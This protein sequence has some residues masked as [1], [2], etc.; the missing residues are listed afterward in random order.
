[1]DFLTESLRSR[2][3]LRVR[4]SSKRTNSKCDDW[5][6]VSSNQELTNIQQKLTGEDEAVHWNSK[7]SFL[8][9]AGLFCRLPSLSQSQGP[10][11]LQTKWAEP[12]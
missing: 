10:A 9:M 11:C 8:S 12:H 3:S 2:G 1:M 6:V 5:K 7:L 4:L